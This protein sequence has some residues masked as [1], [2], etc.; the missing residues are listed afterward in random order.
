VLPDE[1][2][3]ALTMPVLLLLAGREVL[4]DASKAEARARAL[5]PDLQSDVV[6]DVGHFIAMAAPGR[7]NERLLSFLDPSARS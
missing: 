1:A 4:Y 5:I 2:L 3:R 7:V 6:P